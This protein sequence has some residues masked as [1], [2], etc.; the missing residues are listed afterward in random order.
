MGDEEGWWHTA[1][2]R[3]AESGL[4]FPLP[5]SSFV[6]K[7]SPDSRSGGGGV[8]S[9]EKTSC[10]ANSLPPQL[11]SRV[12]LPGVT[13]RGA[14]LGFPSTPGDF[15]PLTSATVRWIPGNLSPQRAQLPLDCIVTHKGPDQAEKQRLR[16]NWKAA[17]PAPSLLLAQRVG[18]D[19][20]AATCG[21][22][23]RQAASRCI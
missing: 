9:Q 14:G 19:C 21:A 4:W 12:A 20:A 22:I 23:S 8:R 10:T 6:R 3:R 18:Q 11:V 2:M 16:G 5:T 1:T 13:A 15:S 7:N 17:G